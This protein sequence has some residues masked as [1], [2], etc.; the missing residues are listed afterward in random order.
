MEVGDVRD[1]N[2]PAPSAYRRLAFARW[3]SVGAAITNS[4]N[5][6]TVNNNPANL[7]A[8]DADDAGNTIIHVVYTD[9]PASRS[10]GIGFAII[11]DPRPHEAGEAGHSGRDDRR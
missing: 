2:A 10:C 3:F 11:D 7:H 6:R 1:A 8:D 4:A 9:R 5:Q